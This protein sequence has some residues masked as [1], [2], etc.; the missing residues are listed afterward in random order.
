MS[1]SQVDPRLERGGLAFYHQVC[2]GPWLSALCAGPSVGARGAWKPEVNYPAL[3]YLLTSLRLL[4]IA[5]QIS[6]KFKKYL[7]EF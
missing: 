2:P 7:M 1:Q 4:R 5:Q 3:G 6:K